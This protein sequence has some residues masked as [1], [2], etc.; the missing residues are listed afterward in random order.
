RD[1]QCVVD[2]RDAALEVA[3]HLRDDLVEIVERAERAQTDHAT[4]R[5]VRVDVLEMLEVL[6]VLEI[7]EQRQAVPPDLFARRLA[8]RGRRCRAQGRDGRCRQGETSGAKNASTGMGHVGLPWPQDGRQ[9]TWGPDTGATS[10][11]AIGAGLCRFFGAPPDRRSDIPVKDASPSRY[12][13][14]CSA[15]PCAAFGSGAGLSD[16][17]LR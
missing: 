14:R 13:D 16:S 7:V 8:G 11:S 4:L 12:W 2:Q 9:A 6:G 15:G 10:G 17:V 3:L 1:Q 5:R